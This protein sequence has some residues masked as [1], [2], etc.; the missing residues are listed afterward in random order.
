MPRSDRDIPRDGIRMY[1]N[2]RCLWSACKA[3]ALS[4]V[5]PQ[6]RC[7]LMAPGQCTRDTR[8]YTSTDAQS[9]EALYIL[10]WSFFQL[11]CS[12]PQHDTSA[13]TSTRPYGGPTLSG[14]PCGTSKRGEGNSGS[15]LRIGSSI[16]SFSSLYPVDN[17][18]TVS[19]GPSFGS[20]AVDFT[21]RSPGYSGL[22]PSRRART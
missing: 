19:L 9:P 1:A 5:W 16:P 12:C 17:P 21:S 13:R 2:G 14:N 10:T 7:Q 22:T 6:S 11:P 8:T 4:D 20:A 18:A 3:R 15:E